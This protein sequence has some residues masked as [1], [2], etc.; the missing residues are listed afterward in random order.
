MLGAL[1]S[2]VSMRRQNVFDLDV[3]NVVWRGS[4]CV[5]AKLLNLKPKGATEST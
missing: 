5:C 4:A 2:L 3:G 1:G